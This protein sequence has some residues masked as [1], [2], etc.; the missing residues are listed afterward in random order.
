[1]TQ[2]FQILGTLGPDGTQTFQPL[3]TLGAVGTQ[4]FHLPGILAT[5]SSS[6]DWYWRVTDRVPR[7]GTDLSRLLEIF[8][9]GT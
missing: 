6:N 2:S 3:G 4:S 9:K 7:S 5:G 8:C 1:M